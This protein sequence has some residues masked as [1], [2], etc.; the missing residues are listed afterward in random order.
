MAT[1]DKIKELMANQLGIS[2]DE[3][4][5]E[6]EIVKDLGADSLDIVE[7][8]MTF[9]EEFGVTVPDEETIDIKTVQ[10]IVDVVEKHM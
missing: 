8:L 9:E 1:I 10:D 2:A 4:T 6:K 5:A 7:M 3:V